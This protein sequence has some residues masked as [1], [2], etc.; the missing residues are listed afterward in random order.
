MRAN[1]TTFAPAWNAALINWVQLAGLV[2]IL[3]SYIV[4]LTLNPTTA[5]RFAVEDGPI[6]NLGAA[7]SLFAAYLFLLCYLRS[8][9]GANQFFGRETKRNVWFLALALLMLVCFGEEISWGQRIF[10]WG[11]PAALKEMNAQGEFNV[12]NL[13]LFQAKHPDG[14]QKSH[15]ELMLNANRLYAIFWL[16]YCVLVPLAVMSSPRMARLAAYLGI[17]LPSLAIGGLFLANFLVFRL[18]VGLGELDRA[19]VSAFDELKETNY[20]F[21]FL[22]LALSMVSVM[23][24][25]ARRVER[26]H[27]V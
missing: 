20:A 5:Q 4:L 3:L 9:G 19:T 6:E 25:L 17:P 10:G 27:P 24:A 22:L 14:A 13:W 12:H 8:A 16:V 1:S 15:L 2:A 11:T 21:G 26:S 23:P 18:I 7:F